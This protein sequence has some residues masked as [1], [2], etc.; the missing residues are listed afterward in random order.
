MAW[1]G[2]AGARDAGFR[3]G[4]EILAEFALGVT[5]TPAQLDHDRASPPRYLARE[6]SVLGPGPRIGD[7]A[8]CRGPRA[9]ARG[10]AGPVAI[11]AQQCH[12]FRH[13]LLSCKPARVGDRAEMG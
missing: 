11:A 7:P 9:S 12:C 2:A 8:N 3:S 13:P 5:R 4:A 1:T 10:I 6:L